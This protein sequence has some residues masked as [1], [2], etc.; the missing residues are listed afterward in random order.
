MAP[1]EILAEQHYLNAVKLLSPL[2]IKVAILSGKTKVSERKT[3]LEKLQNGQI[4]LLL[5]THALI[6]P[7]VVFANLSLVIIDEQHRFGVG[8]RGLLMQ[9][10]PEGIHP[11]IL[12]MTATPIPRTLSM[13]VYGDLDVSIIDELPKG[14]I[15]SDPSGL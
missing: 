6:E 11:H 10:G 2:G 8:Q 12:V 7:G 9:K 13:T 14:R 1:T 3:I 4:D 15:D 5:G